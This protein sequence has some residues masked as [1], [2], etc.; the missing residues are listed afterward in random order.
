MRSFRY[1]AGFDVTFTLMVPEPD[2]VSVQWDIEAGVK[3][4]NLRAFYF[5][6]FISR[7]VFLEGLKLLITCGK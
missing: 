3:G 2:A 6:Y 4:T 7:I 5:S 1:H